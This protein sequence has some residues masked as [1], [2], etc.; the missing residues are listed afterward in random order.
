V[1]LD[2]QE[3]RSVYFDRPAGDGG[4]GKGNSPYPSICEYCQ[5]QMVEIL[6]TDYWGRIRWRDDDSIDRRKV[7]ICPSCGWWVQKEKDNLETA[8]IAYTEVTQFAILRSFDIDSAQ[9]PLNTLRN[10]L[11]KNESRFHQLNPTKF[12]QLV[13]DIFHD[14]YNCEVTHVG[15]TGDAGVDLLVIDSD[16]PLP[17]QVKRRTNAKIWE[18][19]A[20]VRE[21]L[22]AL[23]LQGFDRGAIVTTANHFSEPALEAAGK[24]RA[25]GLVDEFRLFDMKRFLDIFKL[26]TPEGSLPPWRKAIPPVFLEFIDNPEVGEATRERNMRMEREASWHRGIAWS[27]Y[28]LWLRRERN[29]IAGDALG[30]W[31]AAEKEEISNSYRRS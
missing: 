8:T 17:I 15:R 27:A 23:L 16:K 26:V 30:D 6:D 25:L 29:G 19:V 12:E 21:F 31:L 3:T 24:A 2:Y 22:G 9:V 1:I 10:Y 18:P 20:T 5:H 7:S 28:M 4:W 11:R 14:F 13:G